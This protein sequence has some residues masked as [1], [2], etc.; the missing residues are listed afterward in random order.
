MGCIS[1]W[2]IELEALNID[3]S[4]R[5]A[6]KSQALADLWP[7]GQKSNNPHQIPSSIIGRCTSID[8]SS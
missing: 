8:H 3:F 2:A 6:I 5:K 1:K 7:N 4:P